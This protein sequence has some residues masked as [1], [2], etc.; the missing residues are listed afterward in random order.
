MLTTIPEEEF[1]QLC[2]GV[3]EANATKR[4]FNWTTM[5][6]WSN[7]RDRINE[8]MST[9]N[10]KYIGS[11]SSRTAYYLP[12][13]KYG[14]NKLETP[15]CFKVANNIKGVAQ[16]KLEIKNLQTFGGDEWPCFPY[17][18]D[19][20]NKKKLFML[21]EVGTS[22][23]KGSIGKKYF[24]QWSDF[25]RMYYWE[26][27]GKKLKEKIRHWLGKYNTEDIF[28]PSDIYDITRFFENIVNV[29]KDLKKSKHSDKKEVYEFIIGFFNALIEKYPKYNGIF[30]T[31]EFCVDHPNEISAGDFESSE[32]WAFVKRGKEYVAIPIDWGF[33]NEIWNKYYRNRW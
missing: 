8:Y 1:L 21:C 25:S 17:L 10:T 11:G 14:T 19:W 13:G 5:L 16:N 24:Q 9:T 12:Q 6:K 33:N 23:D 32:N 27:T 29:L 15:A 31:I 30:S 20:D 26:G 3:S 4:N 28:A 18:Y 7:T 22:V 2:E